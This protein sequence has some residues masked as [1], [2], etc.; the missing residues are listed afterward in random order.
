MPNCAH[1]HHVPASRSYGG[2][3]PPDDEAFTACG[4]ADGNPCG[5]LEGDRPEVCPAMVKTERLCPY[6]LSDG[7]AESHLTSNGLDDYCPTCGGAHPTPEYAAN[8]MECLLRLQGSYAKLEDEYLE[9]LER[10]KAQGERLA[11]IERAQA[12]IAETIKGVAA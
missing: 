12:H 6:C 7:G 11:R 3:T 1:K 10:H 8:A 5:N 4:L 9:L 2:I